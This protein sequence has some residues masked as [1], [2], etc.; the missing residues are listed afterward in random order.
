MPDLRAR[1]KTMTNLPNKELL[2]VEEVAEY[3]SISRSTVYLW[4]EHRILVREKY[5]GVIR[6]PRESV[7]ACRMKNRSEQIE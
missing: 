1:E 5:R 6:V 3:F 7:L 4:I 2:T